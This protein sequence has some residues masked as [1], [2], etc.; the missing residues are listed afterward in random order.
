MMVR[1][2]YL[3]ASKSEE[4]LRIIPLQVMH[5]KPLE[6]KSKDAK[7]KRGVREIIVVHTEGAENDVERENYIKK[8]QRIQSKQ[9]QQWKTAPLAALKFQVEQYRSLGAEL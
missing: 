1:Y 8:L 6:S 4:F 3:H 9:M 2:P 5:I 7:S